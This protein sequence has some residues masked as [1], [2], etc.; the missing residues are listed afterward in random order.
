MGALTWD[1]FIGRPD[2]RIRRVDLPE[3]GPGAYVCVRS[4]T[5][6][7][8]DAW[9]AEALRL[10]DA[11]ALYDNF[12]AR[13]VARTLC[14]DQGQLLTPEGG[15]EQLGRRNA[16]VLDRLWDA[17]RHLAG[18][19]AEDEAELEKN[20]VGGPSAASTSA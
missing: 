7:E 16:A 1:E 12:R 13:L 19:S 2:M 6:A 3:L 8:R 5:G 10:R 15:V 14:D 20:S 9:E 4:L 17:A 11:G 18:L